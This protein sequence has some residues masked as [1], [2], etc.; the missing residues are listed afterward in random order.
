MPPRRKPHKVAK[1]AS[2]RKATPDAK[3]TKTGKPIPPST[4]HA[5]NYHGDPETGVNYWLVKSEPESRIDPVSKQDVKCPLSD[6]VD[7][8]EDETWD[9]V[10]N[11]EARNN[12]L[13]M[14]KGDIALFYHSNC[15]MPGIVG[16]VEICQDAH[17]DDTQ[18]DPTHKSF[19]RKSTRENP[20]WWCVDVRFRR[21]F[22]RKISLKE[23]QTNAESLPEFLLLTR[24]R[25]S[26]IPVGY[27]LYQ[28]I[29]KME[30]T[31]DMKD[32]LDCE[33]SRLL[34]ER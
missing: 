10:R 23:M 16:E 5:Y 4:S 31:G 19:D 24:G 3:R 29:L 18:F 33:I 7:K 22:R 32:D 1:P 15:A 30:R 27:L 17:I 13:M 6:L 25:L 14:E 28:A 34:I 21:R 12:M 9:G 8:K 2:N 20:K 11:Y 26:V